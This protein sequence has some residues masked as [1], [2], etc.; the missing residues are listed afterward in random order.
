MNKM[1][2]KACELYEEMASSHYQAPSDRNMGRRV[3]GVLEVDQ[4]FA[5]LGSVNLT[6]QQVVKPEKANH[7]TS[8]CDVESAGT[9]IATRRAVWSRG[10]SV[11]WEYE[12]SVSTK[13]QSARSLPSRDEE[14]REL[15]L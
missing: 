2:E 14:S 6:H 3:A 7:G 10:C 13:Q 8:G 9:G 4:L 5:I 1:A 11:C 12:L 15:L